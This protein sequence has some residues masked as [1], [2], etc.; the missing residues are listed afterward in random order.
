MSSV[1]GA[2][3]GLSVSTTLASFA[4]RCSVVTVIVL[5]VVGMV[6]VRTGIS[7]EVNV[8]LIAVVM[9]VVVIMAS[10]VMLATV[11]AEGSCVV[12]IV[13]V[14]VV[15]VA[16]VAV[17]VVAVIVVC[18]RLWPHTVGDCAVI[19]L[20]LLLPLAIMA[21]VSIGSRGRQGCL[22]LF[23]KLGK[24]FRRIVLHMGFGCTMVRDHREISQLRPMQM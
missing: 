13:A 21:V 16:V 2:A 5:D 9:V 6:I 20:L 1:S 24:V 18:P 3:L 22:T 11:V 10:E 19:A 4:A 8:D 12:M 23:D 7:R 14:A 17:A 15:A